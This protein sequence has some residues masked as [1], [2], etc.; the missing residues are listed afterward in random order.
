M[1]GDSHMKKGI[2]ILV[3]VL[4]AAAVLITAT[5][6]VFQTLAE[7]SEVEF[8]KLLSEEL[9][10]IDMGSVA[11]GSYIG[12]FNVFPVNVE[13]SVDVGGG[14]ITDIEIL[15]HV[16]GQGGPAEAI[17][18]AVIEAQSLSVDAV[19]GATYSSIVILYAIRDAFQSERFLAQ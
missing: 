19:S 12:R 11:D 6:I 2:R 17:V 10:D 15:K 16:N 14:R 13:L 1:E 7:K 5:V 18:D 4:A 8:E 3:I 9:P